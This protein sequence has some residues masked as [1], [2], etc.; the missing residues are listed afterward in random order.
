M[1]L[2][3]PS[4]FLYFREI[5]KNEA[6]DLAVSQP[7]GS[8]IATIS[9]QVPGPHIWAKCRPWPKFKFPKTVEVGWC[10]KV[11]NS[12]CARSPLTKSKKEKL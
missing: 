3:R 7:L 1:S 12:V 4:F 5:R 6:T 8:T 9:A 2:T 10:V 11:Y